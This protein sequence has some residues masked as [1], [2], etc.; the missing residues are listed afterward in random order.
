MRTPSQLL[1]AQSAIRAT[2]VTTRSNVDSVRARFG[3]WYEM[4]PRS[5]TQRSDAQRH[6]P[7]SRSAAGRHR[8]DGIRRGLSAAGPSN[9]R[10]ASEG[11]QQHA[12]RVARRPRQPLGDRRGRRRPHRHRAG[13][14]NARR[15]RSI[16]ADGKSPRTRRRARHRVPGLAGSSVGAR[17]SGVVPASAGRIDQV[18]GESAE[19]IPGHLS[20]RFRIG[21][22]GVAVGRAARRLPLLDRPRRSHLP[23]RQPAHQAVPRSGNG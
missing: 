17:A 4:F 22:M 8:G 5:V 7:R 16:R 13:P 3:A 10:D 9:R 18:R 1:G 21:R 15:L 20:D 6:V 11:T 14:R 23:G 2:P 19:E 12:D